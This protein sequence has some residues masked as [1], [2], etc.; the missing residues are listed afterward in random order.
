MPQQI[1]PPKH[2]LASQVD[3]MHRYVCE[4]PTLQRACGVD[5]YAD[6]SKRVYLGYYEAAVAHQSN[7]ISRPYAVVGF[8][9]EAITFQASGVDHR[10]TSG[11]LTLYLTNSLRG[12]DGNHSYIAFL[13]FM[14]GVLRDVYCAAKDPQRDSLLL[15]NATLL[16]APRRSRPE[17]DAVNFDGG[18]PFFECLW[19][20]EYGLGAGGE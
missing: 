7:Q 1:T 4:S 6:I 3:L 5:S 20:I 17:Q 11:A 9:D 13:D 18:T 16:A 15:G 10:I 12:D 19:R 2:A 8:D 14:E